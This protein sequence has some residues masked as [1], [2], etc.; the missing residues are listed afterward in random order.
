M[1]VSSLE[2]GPDPVLPPAA[3]WRLAIHGPRAL[4]AL[5]QI[6]LLALVVLASD[7]K[8]ANPDLSGGLL[9]QLLTWLPALIQGL[10]LGGAAGLVYAAT[11]DAGLIVRVMTAPVPPVLALMHGVIGLVLVAGSIMT[12]PLMALDMSGPN[13]ALLFYLVAPVLWLAYLAT[14]WL[15]AIPAH[16]LDDTR[17]QGDT[18]ALCGTITLAMFAWQ[19]VDRTQSANSYAITDACVTI[20][21][22]F[23]LLVGNPIQPIGINERGWPLYQTGDI[24]VS[25]APACAGIEGLL[26]TIALLLTLVVLER[27]RLY[28]GRALGLIAVAAGLTFVINGLRLALL[29]YI[30]D[31]WSPEIALTG[32]H[33][34]FGVLTLVVVCAAFTIAIRRFASR[35]PAP[36]AAPDHGPRMAE[37]GARPQIAHYDIRL[38]VPQMVMIA[39]LL[40]LGLVSGEFDW[41]YP[42]GVIVVGTLLWRMKDLRPLAKWQVTLLPMLAGLS[43]FGLWLALVPADPLV[44]ARFESA[45][46]DAPIIASC[47]WLVFRLAGSVLLAPL[48][49]EMAFR[50]FLLPWLADRA[51]ITLPRPIA[52]VS[53]LLATSIVFGLVH[54]DVLAGIAAGLVYGAVQMRRG[55]YADAILAH[56]VT[57]ACLCLYALS[58]GQWIYL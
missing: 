34:N 36:G 10:V 45:L 13:A 54:A 58:T 51:Q 15:V 2:R 49:E 1:G 20:A 48:V 9:Q 56:C 11:N 57:N 43:A 37:T 7:T 42:V 16:A 5:A 53:A 50:G 52:R 8:Y 6:V 22:W 24:T 4:A 17:R 27:H 19:Y 18:F 3:G 28:V 35:T 39:C 26:L 55:Q 21:S 33:S 32:F 31:H 12:P 40:L 44:S 23:S 38:I 46:F 25:I 30:G 41:P 47:L 29:F 14:G